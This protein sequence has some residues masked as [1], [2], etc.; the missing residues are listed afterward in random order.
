MT[1][2]WFCYKKRLFLVKNHQKPRFKAKEC[3]FLNRIGTLN[4]IGLAYNKKTIKF[5]KF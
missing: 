1:M 3:L 5:K 4:V 2:D